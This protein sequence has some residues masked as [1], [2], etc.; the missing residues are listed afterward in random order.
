MAKDGL[1]TWSQ[2]PSEPLEAIRPACQSHGAVR[3]RIDE[4]IANEAGIQPYI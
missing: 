1:V 2:F 3:Q 4:E